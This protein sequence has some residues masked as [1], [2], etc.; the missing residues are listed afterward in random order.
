MYISL[1]INSFT[2]FIVSRLCAR[3]KQDAIYA[4]IFRLVFFRI[5]NENFVISDIMR[6]FT[7]NL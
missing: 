3:E 4:P 1:I 7:A 5:I 2:S 6:N